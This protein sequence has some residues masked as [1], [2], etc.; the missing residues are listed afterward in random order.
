MTCR[1][2]QRLSEALA[3]NFIRNY[4]GCV[5]LY[6]SRPALV[7]AFDGRDRKCRIVEKSGR[8]QR[9]GNVARR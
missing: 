7:L 8:T 4:F 2:M 3:H 5:E 9:T 6:E 1:L